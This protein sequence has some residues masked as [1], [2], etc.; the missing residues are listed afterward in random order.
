M[1]GWEIHQ[2]DRVPDS[3]S[4]I[5]YQDSMAEVEDGMSN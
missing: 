3:G 5:L 4:K 1:E 2:E